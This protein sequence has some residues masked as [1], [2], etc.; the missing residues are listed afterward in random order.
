MITTVEDGQVTSI[1]GDRDHP[2]TRGYLCAKAR[3]YVPRITHRDRILYPQVRVGA[4]GEGRFERLSWAEAL[5]EIARR[6]Q[7]IL[8]ESGGQAI[9]PYSYSGTLGIVQNNAMD[10]RFFHR[11]GASQLE[12]T[13]CTAAGE[14]GYRYTMGK[15][16]GPDPEAVDQADLVVLWGSNPASTGPHLLPMIRRARERGAPLVAID[17]RVSRSTRLADHHIALRPGTDACFALGVMR[18]L[19]AEGR[20]DRDFLAR[21]T[22]GFEALAE[23]VEAYTPAYVEAQTGVPAGTLRWF[24]ELYGSRPRSFIR[25]GWGMQRYSNGG[26]AVRTV[27]CLPALTGAWQHPGCGLLLSNMQA[28]PLNGAL[29]QRPDLAPGPVRSVNMVALGDALTELDDP[30]IRALYVYNS[31]PAAVAP[32]QRKVLEGLSRPDLFTVVHELFPTDTVDYADLVLPAT[33]QFEQLDVHV[34]M[35]YYLH[36]NQPATA[37]KG[38]ARSNHDTFVALA[39]ALGFDDPALRETA[40]QVVH[41]AMQDT[42]HW[43]GV[44]Y[45]QL[46]ER[47][48]VRAQTPTRPHLPF[49]NGVF[50]TPSGKIELYSERLLAAGQPALPGYRPPVESPL[51][52][53]ELA[54]RFPLTLISPASHLLTSSSHAHQA[55]E[56]PGQREPWI[57]LSPSDAAERGIRSGDRVR[58]WNERGECQ[59]T[60]RLVDGLQ[61]GVAVSEKVRWPKLSPDR[62]NVNFTTS[63]RLSDLGGGATFHENLVQ[64]ARL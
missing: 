48:Y 39:A 54:R 15:V 40:E 18:L 26:L 35:G 37:P 58:V 45:E 34:S 11:L 63:Q 41:Q 20:C 51:S 53:P 2:I 38:E 46:R 25:L 17:P 33:T 4:K 5:D 60:A 59:L 36:L 32:D 12:R 29:L 22:I 9:L 7:Q 16:I 61:A 56:L 8:V 55:A 64:V 62:R 50:P 31:N 57:E 28:F 13:I 6:F 30:P 47:G 24:A 14:E 21:S 52:Q 3:F 49:A 1:S 10:R 19:I 44:S 27:S 23:Q 43:S 42:E